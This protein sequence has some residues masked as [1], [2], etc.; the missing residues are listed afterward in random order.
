MGH[1]DLSDSARAL[2][3]THSR[4]R[5]HWSCHCLIDAPLRSAVIT[6]AKLLNAAL[7]RGQSLVPD[8]AS[9]YDGLVVQRV[10]DAARRSHRERSWVR[11]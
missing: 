8:A 7:R 10:L 6:W 9:F 2:G 4:R 11:L 3:G 5:E 1:E